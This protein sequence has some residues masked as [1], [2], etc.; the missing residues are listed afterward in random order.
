MIRK[1][2]TSIVLS[3][4]VASGSTITTTVKQNSIKEVLKPFSLG[5]SVKFLGPS[6][7]KDYKS[8]ETYNRFKGGTGNFD[9]KDLDTTGAYQSFHAFSLGYKFKNNWNLSY[10]VT[11]QDEHKDNVKFN[12]SDGS[13]GTRANGRSFNNHRLTLFIPSVLNLPFGWVST[14]IY[15]EK[16]TASN[17]M[18][19]GYGIQPSL[20][21]YSN[22]KNT[23]YGIGS[24]IERDIIQDKTNPQQA[25]RVSI[26]PYIS[27]SLND[28][29]S[30]R[31]SFNFDWDQLDSQLGTNTYRQNLHDFG[32]LRLS[33]TFNK[34]FSANIGLEYSLYKMELKKTAIYGGLGVRI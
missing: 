17:I 31:N 26:A 7:S 29:M 28:S 2:V 5:Y 6:L 13:E 23:Y 8:G 9:G 14:S 19:H 4:A 33:K 1:I 16:P 21:F 3:S 12:W 27:Y 25:L 20:S 24:S 10:N 30:L 22:I 18:S 32:D 15:Y 11:L 34:N